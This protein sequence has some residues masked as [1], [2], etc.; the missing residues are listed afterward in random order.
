MMRLKFLEGEEQWGKLICELAISSINILIGTSE[1]LKT[2]LMT[3]VCR[4]LRGKPHRCLIFF[5]GA[6]WKKICRRNETRSCPSLR[7]RISELLASS[8]KDL[9]RFVDP[10]KLA[11]P[12][13][14]QEL[15]EIRHH[16]SSQL[17]VRRA[18]SGVWLFKE[19]SQDVLWFPYLKLLLT[20]EPTKRRSG[21]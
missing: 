8:S 10:R 2:G 1:R 18:V 7:G 9:T 12:V 5:V 3:P 14:R 11:N 16:P 13:G 19:L 6:I 4:V 21:T 20:R 17:F 15:L